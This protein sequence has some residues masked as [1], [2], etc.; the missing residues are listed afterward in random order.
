LSKESWI[1]FTGDVAV[2]APMGEGEL[3][4][5][6]FELL[7]SAELAAGNLEAPL[8]RRGSPADKAITLR[9]DPDRAE[10]LRRMGF[11]A[12]NL[13]NNHMLDYGAEGL[14][15]TWTHLERA[16]LVHFGS[17]RDRQS[18]YLPALLETSRGIVALLGAASTLPA[19]FAATD[20]RAGVAPVRVRQWFA[21]D[22]LLL[23]EQPGTAPFVHTEA[24][25]PDVEALEEAVREASS[26][27]DFTAVALHWGVPPGWAA[28]SQGLLAEY[29][30]PLARRLID[31]GADL[32]VGHHPHAVHP[33]E[34]YRD[35]LICYSLGN[36]LFNSTIGGDRRDDVEAGRA[37]AGGGVET[38]KAGTRG[39][40][41]NGR[42]PADD[43]E[44]LVDLAIPTAP[45]RNVFGGEEGRRSI[46]LLVDRSK[47]GVSYRFIPLRLSDGGIPSPADG[48]EG[49]LILDRLGFPG[50]P[51][52]AGERLLQR[53]RDEG[54]GVEAATLALA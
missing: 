8:T 9:A 44:P 25:E 43:P 24:Y 14:L 2:Q 50:D 28:P 30:R 38:G 39:A 22:A 12:F 21:V 31:A 11:D 49:S 45:Y 3:S 52:R 23:P 35:R 34:V 1:A 46:L 6:V 29:Q 5:R 37:G 32:V 16:R 47:D 13:A 19:G 26:R 27:A 7:R 42:F 20:E 10:E 48:E 54:L 15:D 4:D 17:G 41:P 51:R 18:S 36:F 53:S 40:P 33:V